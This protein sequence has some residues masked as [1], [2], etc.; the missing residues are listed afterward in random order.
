MSI[1]S[2]T[3]AKTYSFVMGLYTHA[4][5]HVYAIVASTR[6][7]L[8]TRDLPI[9]PAGINKTLAWIAHRTGG[10]APRPRSQAPADPNPRQP[11]QTHPGGR[12]PPLARGSGEAESQPRRGQRQALRNGPNHRPP[13]HQP[14]HAKFHPGCRPPQRRPHPK[15]K[16][17]VITARFPANFSSEKT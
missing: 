9:A 10:S 15:I 17:P 14:G 6:E 1:V 3:V 4:K 12:I 7:H 5:K 13:N 2:Q 16:K 11:R 8:E